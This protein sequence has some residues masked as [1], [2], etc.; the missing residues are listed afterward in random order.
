[1]W[2]VAHRHGCVTP[3]DSVRGRFGSR[4]LALA[5][6]LTGIVATMP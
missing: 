1:M 2:S 6:A 5:V 4:G 3:A